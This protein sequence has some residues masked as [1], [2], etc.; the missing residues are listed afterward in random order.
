LPLQDLSNLSSTG[1][2]Y[3]AAHSLY[4]PELIVLSDVDGIWIDQS[5][6][7]IVPVLA[8]DGL[9][10][11]QSCCIDQ[12]LADL[13]ELHGIPI[14]VLNGTVPDRVEAFFSGARVHVPKTVVVPSTRDQHHDLS[15]LASYLSGV[16]F[17]SRGNLAKSRELARTFDT[18][19]NEWI[20][21]AAFDAIGEANT[22]SYVIAI[23]LE[24]LGA[25]LVSGLVP[26]PLL[27]TLAADQVCDDWL[28]CRH[29][30]QGYRRAEATDSDSCFRRRYAEAAFAICSKH[31]L[32]HFGDL[33]PLA[34]RTRLQSERST[35]ASDL[36][37]VV[38]EAAT[39]SSLNLDSY[40][41]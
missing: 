23:A 13:V 27:L 10:S 33:L 16:G 4:A 21:A 26:L 29:W 30:V 14:T 7:E 5:T 6:R 40:L 25:A 1:I 36:H 37:L 15:I 24:R 39:L 41:S 17:C 12:D 34:L 20:A 19:A 18:T 8:T 31:L 38:S 9:R 2:A 22:A 28:V 11:L 35:L 32:E 3:L